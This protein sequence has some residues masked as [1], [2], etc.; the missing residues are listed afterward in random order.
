MKLPCPRCQHPC[1]VRNG[2]RVWCLQ[3]GHWS[4]VVI[5]VDSSVYLAPVAPPSYPKPAAR[6]EAW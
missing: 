3:C 6:E 1:D 5:R 2:D 4:A